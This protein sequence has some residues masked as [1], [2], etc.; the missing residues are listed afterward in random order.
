MVRVVGLQWRVRCV[1]RALGMIIVGG[2]S[3]A[4]AQTATSAPWLCLSGSNTIGARLAP[5]L[6]EAFAAE[7]G[8]LR[9]AIEQPSLDETELRFSKDGQRYLVHLSFHGTGTG[10]TA[11]R[12]G[13]CDLWMAS[14]PAN[15]DEAARLG[16][17]RLRSAEQETVLALDGLAVIVHPDN[18]VRELSRQQVQALFTGKIRDWSALGGRA[19]RIQLHARDNA[20]G[21]FDTFKNLVLLD[22]PLSP[23]AT[24]YESTDALSAA[25]SQ[26]SNAIGFVGLGGVGTNRA[27]AIRDGDLPAL[28]PTHFNVATEDYAL[29]RRLY[30]YSRAERREVVEA[31]LAFVQRP[32]AQSIVAATGF[33]PLALEHHAVALRPDA[34]AEYRELIADATR[35]SL[36][37]RFGSGQVFLD[38]RASRDLD[39]LAEYMQTPEQQGA[40]LILVGFAERAE[41]SP[42]VTIAQSTDRADFVAREL[43]RRRVPVR[44]IRGYGPALPISDAEGDGARA[45]NRRV[46][47]WIRPPE[48]ES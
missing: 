12:D 40:S 47:V 22:Q 9:D 20:S 45:K 36:S 13:Q 42:M 35:L 23:R 1:L 24:R 34:P 48:R 8:M 11:L 33:V 3:V 41:F 28:A 27:L 31:F 38:S 14:R 29:A 37:F 21:T 2:S 15:A 25:V 6:V 18:P 10:Y 46:E 30:F 43:V 17:D 32:T 4:V 44:H 26:D 5:R 7:Q 16:G 19:G 39:R